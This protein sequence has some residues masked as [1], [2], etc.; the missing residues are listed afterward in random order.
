VLV[1]RACR[2][3]GCR[4]QRWGA[5]TFD[6]FFKLWLESQLSVDR[7]LAFSGLFKRLNGNLRRFHVSR[8]QRIVAVHSKGG[9]RSA[10][11]NALVPGIPD[12]FTS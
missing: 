12:A 2:G 1:I 10:I 3:Y 8:E 4:L 6:V 9:M 7:G 5:S 11:F